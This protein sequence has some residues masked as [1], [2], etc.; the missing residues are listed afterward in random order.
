MKIGCL[1]NVFC[2]THL[3]DVLSLKPLASKWLK[4]AVVRFPVFTIAM[5][6]NY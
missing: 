4:L 3:R 2:E 1:I 6:K 5:Q